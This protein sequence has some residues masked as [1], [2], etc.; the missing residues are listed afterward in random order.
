MIINITYC[1]E[2]WRGGICRFRYS[3]FLVFGLFL[4]FFVF[5]PFFLF[6]NFSVKYS[7]FFL[8][9]KIVI[10]LNF[11]SDSLSKRIKKYDKDLP[12]KVHYV[13][14]LLFH[15]IFNTSVTLKKNRFE[16]ICRNL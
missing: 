1:R 10:T 13:V 5:C 3:L 15:T 8:H 12:G 9:E 4:L 2:Q 11:F 16:K 6:K 7:V 14:T